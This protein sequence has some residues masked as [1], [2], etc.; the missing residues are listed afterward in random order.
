MSL[1]IS[2]DVIY[3]ETVHEVHMTFKYVTEE[4]LIVVVF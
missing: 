3:Y 1:D 2:Y 4:I